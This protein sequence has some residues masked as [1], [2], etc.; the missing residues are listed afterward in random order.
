M[1]EVRYVH[2]VASCGR[3]FANPTDTYRFTSSVGE[4]KRGDGTPVQGARVIVAEYR[5]DSVCVAPL[6][7]VR[8][9]SAGRFDLSS[10]TR[11]VSI[12][13]IIPFDYKS[14]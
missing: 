4:Y 6:R 9:D 1:A 10:V 12:T 5:S 14:C 13:P 2:G 8:T 11:R 3:M 7:S